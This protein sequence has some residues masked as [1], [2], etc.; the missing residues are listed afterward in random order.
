MKIMAIDLFTTHK[1]IVRDHLKVTQNMLDV[2]ERGILSKS[3]E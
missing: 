1:G 2:S 3:N